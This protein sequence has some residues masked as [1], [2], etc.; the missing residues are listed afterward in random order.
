MKKFT[1]KEMGGPCDKV[2]EGASMHEV[3]DMGGKHLMGTTDEMHKAM[4]EQMAHS[5]KEDQEK[6]FAWFQTE[7][8]KKADV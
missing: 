5:S 7:W 3:A 1:C 2:F 8:D 4:R 6:W